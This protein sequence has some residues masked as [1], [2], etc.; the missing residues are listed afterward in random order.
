MLDMA[1]IMHSLGMS[2]SSVSLLDGLETLELLF[3]TILSFLFS[4]SSF[5]TSYILLVA[6][7]QAPNFF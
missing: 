1:A 4:H 6:G 7:Q 5:R 3:E 2:T